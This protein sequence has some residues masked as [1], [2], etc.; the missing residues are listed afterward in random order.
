MKVLVDTG[1]WSLA[2]R[3]K[4]KG[5]FTADEMG[6]VARLTEVIQDGNIVMIGPIRQEILSGI[7][8]ESQFE[9]TERLLAPFSGEEL[10]S[11][12]YVEAAR[13]FNLCRRHGVQCGPIEMLLFS[14]AV[15]KCCMI[16]TNDQGLLRCV[17]VLRKEKVLPVV[18]SEG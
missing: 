3:R 7:K 4:D 14:V 5:S 8:D 17:D 9:T 16:L 18:R 15:R 11:A 10:G 1:I 6:L 13:L 2:L 12:D